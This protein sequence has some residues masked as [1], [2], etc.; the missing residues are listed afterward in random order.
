MTFYCFVVVKSK[1]K[2]VKVIK[3]RNV[4]FLPF[5]KEF[6]F[7]TGVDKSQNFRLMLKL[8]GESRSLFRR[9]GL[10]LKRCEKMKIAYE[11]WTQI[12]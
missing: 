5:F 4:D 3:K 6:I 8:Q 7:F 11:K 9:K 2:V 1:F 12:S 10:S